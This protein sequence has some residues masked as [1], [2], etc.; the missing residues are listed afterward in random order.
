MA[1][2]NSSSIRVPQLA[3]PLALIVALSIA[4]W[5]SIIGVIYLGRQLASCLV[6]I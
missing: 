3:L 5:V 2:T 1:D 6:G 4:S